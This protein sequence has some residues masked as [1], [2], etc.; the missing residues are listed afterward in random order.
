MLEL[1]KYKNWK[2]ICKAMDWKI[3]G[4][5]Y[6]KARLSELGIICKYSK[7]GNSYIIEEIYDIKY[8]NIDLR[9]LGN[10]TIYG[11]NLQQMIVDMCSISDVIDNN[12][13]IRISITK[14]MSLFN[15]INKNYITGRDNINKL[16]VAKKIPIETIYD[17]YD[18]SFS[19]SRR[20]I[21]RALNSLQNKFLINF[22]NDIMLILDDDNNRIANDI[23][24]L[25]ITKIEDE[26]AKEMEI[27]DKKHVF[28][29]R[30]WDEFK[31]RVNSILSNSSD[32]CGYYKVI[33]IYPGQ[34]F[35]KM[36]L[37]AKQ[38]DNIMKQLNES[39]IKSNINSSITRHNHSINKDIDTKNKFIKNRRTNEYIRDTNELIILTIEYDNTN[40]NLIN[41]LKCIKGTYSYEDI[42]K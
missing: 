38:K 29:Q 23:D 5:D 42:D 37:E 4:G 26:V 6:K 40:Y 11:D 10:N 32:I 33:S 1:K 20:N 27:K 31:S 22:K 34:R 25:L 24:I 19:N 39:M 12:G 21:L 41:D 35:M 18:N 13:T 2:E 3:T 30:R 16:S 8:E 15:L 17:F 36:I 7:N 9:K 28:L 14:M